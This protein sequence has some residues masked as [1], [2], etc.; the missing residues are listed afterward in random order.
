MTIY[1]FGEIVYKKN[2]NLILES[3][4]TGYMIQVACA[5][6][7]ELNTKL[8]MHL[9]YIYNEFAKTFSI[10]GFKDYMERILFLDLINVNGIGAKIAMNILDNGWET[11]ADLVASANYETL[12]KLNF[13]NEKNARNII[14]S[15][16][17]KWKKIRNVSNSNETAKNINALSDVSESLKMLGFKEKQISYALSKIKISEQLEDMV[18]QSIKLIANKYHENRPTT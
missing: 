9:A 8:K 14:L 10:Y 16:Q 4:G 11:V 6:R 13:V 7:F 5:D 17:D 12:S 3:Y 18:E 15:L 2:K 1:K